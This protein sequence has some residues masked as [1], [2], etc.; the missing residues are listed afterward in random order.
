MIA[1]ALQEV[2]DLGARKIAFQNA[3]PL[4]CVPVMNSMH[5][6]AGSICAE[7]P[8]ALARIHNAYLSIS[9]KNLESQLPGFKYAIFDY[10]NSLGD[11]VMNPSKYGNLLNHV[12]NYQR[13][14]VLCCNDVFCIVC[15]GFKEGRVACCGSGAFK[16]SGCGR[17]YD[18]GT[19]TY[20]LCSNPSEYVWFDGGHTTENANRQLAELLWSGAPSTTGP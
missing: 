13:L 1:F 18:N 20:E 10:Y 14:S 2:Y 15:V 4:G 17:K 6:E 11:R 3:G 5:P 9:L 7:G 8:S 19:K 16:A 12:A